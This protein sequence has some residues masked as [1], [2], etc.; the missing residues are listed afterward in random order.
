MAEFRPKKVIPLFS[1]AGSSPSENCL[2]DTAAGNGYHLGMRE[3]DDGKTLA[4][5]SQQQCVAR[6]QGHLPVL[7]P[8]RGRR[9]VGVLAIIL[10]VATW[11]NRMGISAPREEIIVGMVLDGLKA[12][13][14]TDLIISSYTVERLTS[15][16][17]CRIEQL[18]K[19][20]NIRTHFESS[21]YALN[22]SEVTG[23]DGKPV[24]IGA[25]RV[26]LGFE[27]LHNYPGGFRARV[28]RRYGFGCGY[29]L[30]MDFWWSPSG[31]R[32]AESSSGD[33]IIGQGSP[34]CTGHRL[35][36]IQ[37]ARAA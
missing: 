34:H 21:Q 14:P 11:F 32:H 33:F 24:K 10:A 26:R 36:R 5:C 7:S 16:E 8:L 35:A 31:W 30:E 4:E 20:S 2:L 15:G 25:K 9:L 1:E 6:P 18:A 29:S 37:N 3:S 28:S 22:A 27:I 19:R 23:P 17:R 13:P 12:D